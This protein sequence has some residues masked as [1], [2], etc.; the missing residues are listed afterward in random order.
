MA[1][2]KELKSYYNNSFL[3]R[4]E[5]KEDISV[6]CGGYT[7]TPEGQF[8]NVLDNE[9]HG[10]IFSTYLR[11]Y[12]ED[13]YRNE[14]DSLHAMISLTKLNHIV[15]SGIKL[16]DCVVEGDL[17]QGY[18]LLVFPD[19]L[20]VLTNAQK[21]GCLA[22]FASNKSIFGNRKKVELQIHDFSNRSY[23]QEELTERF[24]QE[25]DKSGKH[26]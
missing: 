16:G 15:Y 8:V 22:L 24:S 10:S 11:A 13:L 17:E 18:A 26:V 9:D 21:K 6:L 1:S 4:V 3:F 7:I 20:S 25:L 14:E 23:S 12:L 19:D 2:I 5:E